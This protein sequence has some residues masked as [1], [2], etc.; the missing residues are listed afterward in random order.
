[1]LYFIKMH[2]SDNIIFGSVLYAFF[3]RDEKTYF[4]KS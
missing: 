4:L 1:L 2:K 3:P